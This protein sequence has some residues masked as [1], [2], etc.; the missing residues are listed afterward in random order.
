MN[1]LI[2]LAAA[3]VFVSCNNED[4]IIAKLNRV[5]DSL[6]VQERKDSIRFERIERLINAGM[7]YDDAANYVDSTMKKQEI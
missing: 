7:T 4:P 1:K 3:I 5:K 6:K 2:I